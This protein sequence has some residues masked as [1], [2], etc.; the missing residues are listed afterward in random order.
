MDTL[1]IRKHISLKEN[2][3]ELIN[4][5]A[6]LLGLSFSE[7]LRKSALLFIEQ[8]EELSLAEFLNKHC[9]SVSKE[10]QAEID[11]MNIDYDDLDGEEMTIND[12]L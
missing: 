8:K 12:F 3:Y 5:N 4:K 6:K 9:E 7:F 1:T 11:A 10:E 2:E